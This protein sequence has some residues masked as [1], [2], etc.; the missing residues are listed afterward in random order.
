[1]PRRLVPVAA[2]AVVLIAARQARATS[3]D[4]DGLWLPVGLQFGP[5]AVEESREGAFIGGEASFVSYS[6]GV[7]IGGFAD[8]VWDTGPG[9]LRHVIGPEIGWATF[10]IDVGYL[11]VL[12]DGEYRPGVAARAICTVGFAGLYGRYGRVFG[13]A[14]TPGFGELGVQLKLPIPLALHAPDRSSR[15]ASPRRVAGLPA[16]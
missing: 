8:A 2:A 12:Q 6:R 7:W 14:P 16:R 13:D 15:A 3:W 1:M 11:G 10:G 9:Q 4:P 5:S